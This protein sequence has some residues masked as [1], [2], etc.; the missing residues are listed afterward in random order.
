MLRGRCSLRA[1]FVGTK[2]FTALAQHSKIK[3]GGSIIYF[4]QVNH[5]MLP[6]WGRI[7]MGNLFS[8]DVR[9]LWSRYTIEWYPQI[10]FYLIDPSGITYI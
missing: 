8:I 10:N 1:S 4:S 2:P 3:N 9:I 5:R 7:M 6:R